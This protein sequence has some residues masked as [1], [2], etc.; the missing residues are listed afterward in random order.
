MV[1]DLCSINKD[2]YKYEFYKS[3]CE[4]IDIIPNE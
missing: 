4:K 1:I 2:D 3:L